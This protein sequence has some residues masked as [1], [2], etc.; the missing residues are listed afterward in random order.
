LLCP[1][2]SRVHRY[3]RAPLLLS[4]LFV[5]ATAFGAELKFIPMV[6]VRDIY[7]DNI[8]FDYNKQVQ[9]SDLYNI[10]SPGVKITDKTERVDASIQSRMNIIRYH[11][12]TG[13]NANDQ[14]H[15]SRLRYRI[16]ERW[17]M[18]AEAGYTR[19]S[20]IDRDIEVSG[21][22]LGT[23]QRDYQHYALQTNY[24]L[25]EKTTTQVSY[26]YDKQA[27]DETALVALYLT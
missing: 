23:T 11:E 6:E 25:T 1:S 22:L 9:Q 26:A 17:K 10:I 20:Q 21:L 4:F 27:F 24:T 15:Q 16:S 2:A 18:S 3:L 8:F 12:N 5:G 7:N 14:D 13:L 19:D